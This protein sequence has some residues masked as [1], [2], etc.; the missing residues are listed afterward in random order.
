MGKGRYLSDVEEARLLDDIYDNDDSDFKNKYFQK[1]GEL[2]H[3]LETLHWKVKIDIIEFDQTEK[4]FF[5]PKQPALTFTYI[6]CIS[7]K[8][9]IPDK[10]KAEHQR[11]SQKY[12]DIWTLSG[13][14]ILFE[15]TRNKSEY[16]YIKGGAAE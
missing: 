11:V 1:L 14:F 8:E 9:A 4:I 15:K 3:Q 2:V 13:H 6:V 5:A 12:Y 16:K 7:C 10:K